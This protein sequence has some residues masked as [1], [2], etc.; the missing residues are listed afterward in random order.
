MARFCTACGNSL[1]TASTETSPVLTSTNGS[2]ANSTVTSPLSPLSPKAHQQSSSLSPSLKSPTPKSPT[3]KSP[4]PSPSPSPS[5]TPKPTVTITNLTKSKSVG[6]TVSTANTSATSLKPLPTIPR[7]SSAVTSPL[8]SPSS[9]KTPPLP[10]KPSTSTR[11][12][13]S[14]APPAPAPAPSH[15]TGSTSTTTTTPSPS[16]TPKPLPFAPKIHDH[17]NSRKSTPL[18][19]KAASTSTPTLETQ[20]STGESFM[21][22]KL[23]RT[24]NSMNLRAKTASGPLTLTTAEDKPSIASGSFVKLAVKSRDELDN[25]AQRETVALKAQ[26][27]DISSEKEMNESPPLSPSPPQLP[28]KPHHMERPL[29]APPPAPAQPL[30]PDT[31]RMSIPLPPPVDREKELERQKIREAEQEKEMERERLR[32]IERDERNKLRLEE[33][34]KQRLQEKEERDRLR[35]EEMDKERLKK[36]ERDEKE[37]QRLVEKER[38]RERKQEEKKQRQSDREKKKS[39]RLVD[40]PISGAV[41]TSDGTGDSSDEDLKNNS[42]KMTLSD[43]AEQIKQH[44]EKERRNRERERFNSSPAK[45]R[46]FLSFLL[47]SGSSPSPTAGLDEDMVISSPQPSTGVSEN[48]APQA[49]PTAED[50]SATEHPQLRKWVIRRSELSTSKGDLSPHLSSSPTGG[51]SPSLLNGLSGGSAISPISQSQ[52]N[53]VAIEGSASPFEQQQAQQQQRGTIDAKKESAP[54]PAPTLPALPQAVD[55]RSKVIEE[56]IVTEADYI[57]DMEIMVWMRKEMAAQE[58]AKGSMLDEINVMFSNVEQL[59]LVNKELFNK[60]VTLPSSGD[61]GESIASGFISM[62]DFLKSYYVY[63]SNQ[64]KALSTFNGLRGKNCS[65]LGY[66]LTRRECRSLPFD[67]FLIKPVQRVC[68]YPLL[69]RELIKSTPQTMPAYQLLMHA[70]TK[71]ESIV[72]TVNEK[73]REFDG[74]MRM[75]DIQTRLVEGGCETKILAPSRKL[76]KEGELESI[77]MIVPGSSSSQYSKKPK[78]GF[79]YLCN[80]LF[81]FAQPV[82]TDQLTPTSPL[83]LKAYI[84]LDATVIRCVPND[85]NS[86]ELLYSC[87]QV[88]HFTASSPEEKQTLFNELETHIELNMKNEYKKFVEEHEK[89]QKATSVETYDEWRLAVRNKPLPEPPKSPENNTRLSK[90]LPSLPANSINPENVKVI[91]VTCHQLDARQVEIDKESPTLKS[92]KEKIQHKFSLDNLEF[93]IQHTSPSMASS[94][95]NSIISTDQDLQAIVQQNDVSTLEMKIF[96][97]K[98]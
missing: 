41:A 78:P 80:D 59:L 34:E 58:E 52:R 3:P 12:N 46:T 98:I 49:T 19:L 26:E 56:I 69:I 66:L 93:S 88:W 9:H 17:A 4:S 45:G 54:Q 32:Q 87:L 23:K 25:N 72:A 89:Q 10:P 63:C 79:Y 36:E 35:K 21:S 74:Q 65:F 94:P 6:A 83:K 47:G 39:I 7:P 57:R 15:S 85:P 53:S 22:V 11:G 24:S 29:P 43:M 92:L 75:Y 82:G 27:A 44:K 18:P 2:G 81:L 95:H 30:T 20:T 96:A 62:A 90:A 55:I 67:S 64:Q 48:G 84:P 28:K 77:G 40:S 86:F 1:V 61:F 38:E 5:T 50:D 33:R 42:P 91:K 76:I 71:I 8:A 31:K 60:F 70:Q 16:P 37:R 73:K 14:P 51:S 13:T 68:K 97:V